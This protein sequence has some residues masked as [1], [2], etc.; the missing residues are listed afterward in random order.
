MSQHTVP[1]SHSHLYGYGGHELISP[2]QCSC[3]FIF[4]DAEAPATPQISLGKRILLRHTRIRK[5]KLRKFVLAL[6][7]FPEVED[8]IVLNGEEWSVQACEDIQILAQIPLRKQEKTSIQ[9]RSGR[10]EPPEGSQ[11]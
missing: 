3:G 8:I 9:S 1:D 4:N 2:N 6:P 5:V 7:P 10:Q 11:G